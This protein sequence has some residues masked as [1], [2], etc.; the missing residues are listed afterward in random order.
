MSIGNGPRA[1]GKRLVLTICLTLTVSHAV[2][3]MGQSNGP[4][5]P[6]FFGM[7]VNNVP[8]APW[9]ATLGVPFG[10]WRTLGLEVKWSDLELCDGGSNPTNSCYMWTNLDAS[11]AQAQSTGQDILYTIYSTPTWASSAPTDTSC[12]RGTSFPPGSCDPPNDIDAVPGSGLGDGTNLHFDNFLNALMSHVGTGKVKYWEVWDEPNVAHAW[13]GTNA[14]LVRLAKDTYTIMKGLDSN[15]LVTTPP[16]VGDGIRLQFPTYLAAGGSQYADIISYHG[17]LQTGTC[18][19]DCPIPENEGPLVVNLLGELQTAGLAGKPLFDTEGSWG[20]YLGADAITDPDQQVA[21]TGRYY[22]MHVSSGVSRL[23][24]YSWNNQ[25][26]GHFYDTTNDVMIS[27]GTAYEQLYDWME[28]ATLVAPCG[29]YNT[30]WVC[31][32]TRTGTYV[33]QAIWD[34]DPTLTCS[35]GVCP[36]VSTPVPTNF[37]QYQ[38]LAGNVTSIVGH[39]I[40][41]GS[42]PLLIVGTTPDISVS[43]AVSPPTASIGA[44]VTFTSVVTNTTGSAISSVSVADNLDPTLGFISCSVTPKGSCGSGSGGITVTF[45]SMASGET[46]TITIVAKLS[47]EAVGTVLNTFTA[48]WI[49]GSDVQSDNW[50]TNGVIVGTPLAGV[51]PTSVSFGNQTEGTT[52]PTKNITVNNTGTGDLIINTIGFSGANSADFGFTSTGLP[53]TISPKS[54]TTIGVTFTPGGIGNRIGS[55]FIYDNAGSGTLMVNLAGTGLSTTATALSSSLNPS[56]SGQSVTFTAKVTC[57]SGVTPTGTMTFKRAGVVLGSETMANGSATYTTSTLPVGWQTI[58]A[59]YS[60]DNNCGTS[61]GSLSQGVKLSSSVTLTSSA[62]PSTYGQSVTFTAHVT[63][64]G[65]GQAT[66]QITFKSGKTSVGVVTLDSSG[67]ATL[68]TS[69]LGVGTHSL[70]AYYGGNSLYM[71]ST[72]SVLNQVVNAK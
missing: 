35:N 6:Q 33:A 10:G 52:S 71:P 8:A 63:A 31:P 2:W 47:N 18:P 38:D 51:K 34:V 27:S 20:D 12:T 24:W 54:Q 23:Y 61:T 57:T 4:I 43:E 67:N 22:L 60:G 56:L 39:A 32:F 48:N 29:N 41:A 26:N 68:T 3:L 44:D 36:T 69:T 58:N 14:Q 11:I 17:Y 65:A 45:S 42:K 30:I 1:A 16:F 55:M 5:E 53:I 19:N 46:D 49:N 21:F 64:T 15:S 72:S 7:S 40:P 62:N 66:G 50:A 9:P 25:E 59:V 70:T 28:G 13:R 37:T